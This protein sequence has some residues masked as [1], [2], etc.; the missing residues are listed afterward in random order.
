MDLVADAVCNKR[1]VWQ[2]ERRCWKMVPLFYTR[3]NA[4]PQA[5]LDF[6]TGA[7]KNKV[8]GASMRILSNFR[9]NLQQLN[10]NL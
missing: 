5:F 6:S 7:L 9:L 2:R 10:C 4:E 8:S 3:A 1:D